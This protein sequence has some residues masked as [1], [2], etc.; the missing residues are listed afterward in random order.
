M[1]GGVNERKECWR[2]VEML[3]ISRSQEWQMSVITVP[4]KV[5]R[6]LEASEDGH[7]G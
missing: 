4:Q 3:V 7:S 1:A 2:R 5:P 6:V